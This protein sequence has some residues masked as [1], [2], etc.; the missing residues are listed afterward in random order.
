[1]QKGHGPSNRTAGAKFL[2]FGTSKDAHPQLTSLDFHF[3]LLYVQNLKDAPSDITSKTGMDFN[4]NQWDHIE[5]LRV[6]MRSKF[7][8]VALTRG[9]PRGGDSIEAPA[10][11]RGQEGGVK[12]FLTA[13]CA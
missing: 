10:C 6:Q 2:G 8:R 13:V 5:L 3:V 7:R 9:Q 4:G 11:S 12:F 1:M